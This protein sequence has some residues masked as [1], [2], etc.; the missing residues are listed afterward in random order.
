[1]SSSPERAV[2]DAARPPLAQCAATVLMIRPAAFGANPET[3]ASNAFQVQGVVSQAGRELALAEFDGAAV[4]LE[5]AGVEVIVVADTPEPPKPDA[6]FPNNWLSLH[7]DGTAV[8]YPMLSPLRRRERRRDVITA[9]ESR[10]FLVRRILDLSG[11][12]SSEV[13]LEGTGSTVLDH[14]GRV[15]YACVSPRT[16]VRPLAQLTAEI[17]YEPHVF[18]ASGPDGAPLYHTN[19]LMC[20]GDR[21]AAAC[22]QAVGDA[23]ERRRLREALMAGGRELIEI[24]SAQMNSFAGNMLALRT[25]GGEPIVALSSTAWQSLSPAQR[26][27]LERQGGVVTASLPTIERHGGGSLR[28]MLAEVFLPRAGVALPGG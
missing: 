15:A 26:G 10:G 27:A 5:R 13:Y 9:I 1:M 20:V 2:R 16:N 7:H 12:E 17:G 3:V 22:L 18:H 6:V 28:C 14:A 19:V 23:V 11:W 4:A 21:F 25:G 24:S 8:R